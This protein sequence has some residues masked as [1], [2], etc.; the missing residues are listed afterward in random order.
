MSPRAR[1]AVGQ[2]ADAAASS[3]EYRRR[4]TCF[5]EVV[6]AVAGQAEVLLDDGVRRGSDVVKARA[7]GEGVPDRPALARRAGSRRPAGVTRVPRTFAEEID[8]TLALV[9]VRDCA[10]LDSS[11]LP[12]RPSRGRERI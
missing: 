12:R 3:A 10:S 4:S 7:R 9:G 11:V 1:G 6:A 2:R 8:R 5:P